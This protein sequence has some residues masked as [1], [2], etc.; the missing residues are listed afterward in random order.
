MYTVLSF[1]FLWLGCVHGMKKPKGTYV[2]LKDI[3]PYISCD[4]CQKAMAE[5]HKL[6]AEARQTA[7]KQKLEEV[8][9]VEQLD[10]LCKPDNKTA[11]WIR[12]QDI[13]EEKGKPSLYPI[14]ICPI[15]IG[16]LS[17]D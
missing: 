3:L 4:V 6:V 16:I 8:V 7:F 5:I 12:R 11:Q 14:A 9:I 17:S 1:L 2:V 10:S 15:L 13:V